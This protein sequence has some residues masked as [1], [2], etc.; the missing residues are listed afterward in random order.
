MMICVILFLEEFSG[1]V[2]SKIMFEVID[3]SAF[4]R[5]F[6]LTSCLTFWDR[7]IWYQSMV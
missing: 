1:E 6:G 3:N 7:Y 2:L 5:A 4:V